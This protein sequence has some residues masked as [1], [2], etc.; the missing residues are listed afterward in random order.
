MT[1]PAPA[2][3]FLSLCLLYPQTDWL[4]HLQEAAAAT[5]LPWPAELVTLAESESL[6]TLQ[7]EHTRLFVNS[8][9]G[10]SCPPYEAAYVDGHLLTA[11]TAAVADA[12]ARWGLE[13]S[14]EM[15]DFLPVEL[16]FVAYLSELAARSPLPQDRA[17]IEEARRRFESEHLRPWLPRF[18]ADLQQHARLAFYREVGQRL[19]NLAESVS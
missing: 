6:E 8:A 15:A 5:N 10:I 7:I 17:A 4:L 18:A 16:Q 9:E 13:H 12:Y 11:T 3:H 1:A 19:A 14:L 2:Y